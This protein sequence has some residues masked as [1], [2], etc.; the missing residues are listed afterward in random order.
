[1]IFAASVPLVALRLFNSCKEISGFWM[2]KSQYRL[3]YL[4]FA[5]ISLL[6]M[7]CQ[8]NYAQIYELL[9]THFCKLFES[10]IRNMHD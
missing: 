3:N 1:V 6:P 8:M 2:D 7:A 4:Y 9:L 10:S 5:I